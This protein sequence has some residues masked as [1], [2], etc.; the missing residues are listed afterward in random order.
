M[1][2]LIGG[3]RVFKTDERVEAYGSVDELAAFTALLADNMRADAA[4]GRVDDPNR[5][6][7]AADVGRGLLAVGESRTRSP[8]GSGTVRGSKS[9]STPCR[10]VSN[11]STIHDSRRKRR[12][13]D[14]PR[15]PYR[16]PPR[17]TLRSAP[18]PNTASIHGAGLA[19]PSRL[20]LPLDVAYACVAEVL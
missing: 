18:T 4:D 15:L 2:S 3:E 7:F 13:V 20:F 5:I 1:T 6:L 16:L 11:R 12:R 8:A 9:V 17:R 19:Q 14:V 10:R